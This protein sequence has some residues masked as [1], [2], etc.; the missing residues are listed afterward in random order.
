MM[1][2]LA[3]SSPFYPA[4]PNGINIL[5]NDALFNFF[6]GFSE[7]YFIG[8]IQGNTNLTHKLQLNAN[9]IKC[10]KCTIYVE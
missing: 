3:Y 5:M 4:N 8:G 7:Q 9:S 2:Q 1:I 6:V 10:N